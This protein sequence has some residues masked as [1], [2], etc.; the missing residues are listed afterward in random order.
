MKTLIKRLGT[1]IGVAL[2]GAA[3]VAA[4]PASA[5]E[6]SMVVKFQDLDLSRAQD[7]STLYARIRA[8]AYR[9]CAAPHD[10]DIVLI[11]WQCQQ[12]VVS[13]VVSQIHNTALTALYEGK[14]E[15]PA[16]RLASAK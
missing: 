3:G 4:L 8:A 7:V 12:H 14:K 5:G 11:E 9:V 15:S 10:D 16:A 1:V 2:I 13:Q 6:A